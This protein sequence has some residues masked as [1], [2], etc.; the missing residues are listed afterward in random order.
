VRIE[1]ENYEK[2]EQVSRKGALQILISDY[3]S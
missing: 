1:G 2:I 3:N